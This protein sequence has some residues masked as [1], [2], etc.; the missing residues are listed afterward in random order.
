MRGLT[1]AWIALAALASATAS[2]AAEPLELKH[3]GVLRVLVARQNGGVP[4]R[5][6]FFGV[7]PGAPAGFDRDVLERFAKGQGLRIEPVVVSGYDQLVPDLLADKGDVIEG[8]FT[9]T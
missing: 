4:S 8:S 1:A 7:E 3:P 2:P 5:S 9:D 6:P